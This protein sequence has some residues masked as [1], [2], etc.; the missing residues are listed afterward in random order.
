MGLTH[1]K[2]TVANPSDRQR[3]E[4]V[5]FLVDSGALYSVV[6]ADVLDRLGIASIATQEFILAN[7]QTFKRRKGIAM[8]IY[9]ERVGGADVVFGEG[10]D[11]L[12]LGSTALESLGLGLDPLKREFIPLPMIIA[13]FDHA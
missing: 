12:L 11:A 8:Y 9:G 6:P 7:G 2:V 1:A 4:T 5:T 3:A 10:G 13:A